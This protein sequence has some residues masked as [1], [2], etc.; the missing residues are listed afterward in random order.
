[1]ELISDTHTLTHKRI[2]HTNTTQDRVRGINVCFVE[3]KLRLVFA[4]EMHKN[5]AEI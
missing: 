2:R 3:K 1:M 5:A 4:T